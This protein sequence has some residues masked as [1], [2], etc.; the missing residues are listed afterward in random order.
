MRTNS[1]QTPPKWQVALVLVI[2]VMAVSTAAVLVRLA[3]A[4]AG[5]SGVGFSLVLAA[6]RL[7]IAALILAPTWK[8]IYLARPPVPALRYAVLAGVAL[9]VHFATWITSLSYTSIAASTTLVTTNPIWVALLSRFWLGERLPLP[10]WMGIIL[11]LAGG[12]LIGWSSPVNASSWP[13]LG[14]TLALLGAW[15]ASLYF[16]LGQQSQ[17]LGL[18]TG[19]YITVAY[20]VAAAVLLPLPWLTKTSFTGYPAITYGCIVLMALLP[21]LIGHT[22]FNWA[23]RWVSPTLVALVILLEPVVSSLL[24]YVIF[25]EIPAPGV[26]CGA[27]VLLLGVGRAAIR[28][29]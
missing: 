3:I 11:A 22:S 18:S 13:L 27:V 24:G 26:F 2:G 5:V 19:R 12:I 21:Q 29:I 8:Q 1:A 10:T 25:Q 7:A 23:L 28:S 15:A 17:A 9:A 14:N 16:L 20:T 4:T 6:S